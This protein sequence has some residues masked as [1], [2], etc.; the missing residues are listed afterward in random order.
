MEGHNVRYE[1]PFCDKTLSSQQLLRHIARFHEAAMLHHETGSGQ[2]NLRH[3]DPEGTLAVTGWRGK[4][5]D[6]YFPKNQRYYCCFGCMKCYKKQGYEKGHAKCQAEHLTALNQIWARNQGNPLE[7]AQS[8]SSGA[9]GVQVTEPI[10]MRVVESA[11]QPFEDETVLAILYKALTEWVRVHQEID[12]A[13]AGG[14]TEDAEPVSFEEQLE[15]FLGP[16]HV[17]LLPKL[18]FE[19]LEAAHIKLFP[20]MHHAP[21]SDYTRV[22][23]KT[24]EESP[25]NPVNTVVVP[26]Y[27]EPTSLPV[28]QSTKKPPQAQLIQKP[29]W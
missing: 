14:E 7:V 26:S 16:R 13:A 15:D 22:P 25:P 27:R 2:K 19:K 24:K 18:T 8:P 10:V 5:L 9:G 12:D 28:L 6:L 21:K 3:F 20:K 29:R 23:V 1:C 17:A 4:P 11:K